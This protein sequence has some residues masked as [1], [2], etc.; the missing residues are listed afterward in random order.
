M[1]RLLGLH[2]GRLLPVTS[3][4]EAVLLNVHSIVPSAEHEV[5]ILRNILIGTTG[6]KAQRACLIRILKQNTPKR[7]ISQ[8]LLRRLGDDSSRESYISL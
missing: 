2:H 4:L 5:D 6:T 8:R 7:S 3:K 1:L